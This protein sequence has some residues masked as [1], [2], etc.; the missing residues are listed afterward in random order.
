MSLTLCPVCLTVRATNK[1]G[2]IRRHSCTRAAGDLVPLP[3]V[4]PPL[5]QNQLRRLHPL[6]E[7]ALKKAAKNEARWAIRAA[8]PRPRIG[9]NVTLHWRMPDARRR[10]GDGAAPTLKVVLD[11][12]V[13]ED[14][15]PDDS[16]VHV[17]HSGVT[18]HPPQRKMPGSL[19]LELRD[20]DTAEEAS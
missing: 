3:W 18:C 10:D 14:I 15:I 8:R 9:A 20:P 6:R 11:A 4:T 1:D 13:A 16:W 19:W 12:L 2:T 17:P 7:A 5:T